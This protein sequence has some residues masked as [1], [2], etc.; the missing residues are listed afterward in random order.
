MIT[1]DLLYILSFLIPMMM[2]PVV[3]PMVVLMARR[4]RLTDNPNARKI[5]DRPVAVMGGTVIM[6]VICI[7][8]I[9]INVFYDLSGLFPVMCVMMIL[10]I[11]G[12]LDDNIGLTWQFKLLMQIFAIL[13]LFF[14]GNFGVDSLY[15]LF[16]LE[17]M[18][19]WAACLLTLF[20]GLLLLNAVNFVDGID[21]LASG[22]GVLAGV[23]MGYWNVRHGFTTQAILS[24][25]IVGA[26]ASFFVFNVFSERYKM[27]M[28]DSGSLVLGLFIFMMACPDSYYASVSS[29][30]VDRYF[31]SFLVALL[32]AM[33]FD[34]FRVVIVRMLNG[35][36]PFHPDRTHLHHAYV[37][38]G[39]SH[40]LAT[41]KIVL[42]NI[43]VLAVWYFTAALGMNVALQYLIVIA[44]GVVFI[45]MPY[46]CLDY[47]KT[48][49][50]SCYT[51]I[52]NRCMRRSDSLEVLSRWVRGIIDGRR[53]QI[54]SHNIK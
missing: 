43:A 14:G 29:F 46:F 34:L 53:K 3:L 27:Y 8:S 6:L 22:L 16:G 38:A 41:I 30:L 50:L 32:S 18:P 25:T 15:G 54:V 47:L 49:R 12:M 21:G 45:W 24:F 51:K 10:Y 42:Q 31:V 37:D 26:M 7:S 52:S 5:Q 36:T 4:K 13:L 23:V 33:I 17:N 48:K 35:K 2:M 20:A 11:F 19:M 28:G 40:L 1:T 44:A 9:V 39:M